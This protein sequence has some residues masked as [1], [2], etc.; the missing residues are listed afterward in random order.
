VRNIA[1][2]GEKL[3]KLEQK[4]VLIKSAEK[5]MKSRLGPW[6]F[7]DFE[8]F[9]ISQHSPVGLTT[10]IKDQENTHSHLNKHPPNDFRTRSKEVTKAVAC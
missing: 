1:C 2:A 3:N 5:T 9:F 7:M 8:A 10:Y 4:E 6:F